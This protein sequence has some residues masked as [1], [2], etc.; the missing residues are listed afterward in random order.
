MK[1]LLA[2]WGVTL[3]LV[4][5]TLLGTVGLTS[6]QQARALPEQ[7]V[8]QKLWRV[9]VFTIRNAEGVPLVVEV[10]ADD[11]KKA[12]IITVFISEQAAQAAVERVKSE[13]PELGSVQVVPLSLA[14]Y[15]QSLAEYRRRAQE[16]N[17][18]RII[19]ELVPE[20]KQLEAAISMLRQSEQEEERV[21]GVPLFFARGGEDGELLTIQKGGNQVVPLFFNKEDLQGMLD[22]IKQTNPNEVPDI[23]IDVAFLHEVIGTLKTEEDQWLNN[24]VLV[25]SRESREFLRSL[26]PSQPSQNENE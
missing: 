1:N 14:E 17:S 26:Q 11:E 23:K 25:P 2:R 3:S 4:G 19:F 15:Y 20:R 24:I 16:N 8:V 18:D 6:M 10:V 22:S 9:P 7:D 12:S 13:N 21:I 5:T